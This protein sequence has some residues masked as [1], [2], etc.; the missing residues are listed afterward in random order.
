MK[1]EYCVKHYLDKLEF[2]QCWRCNVEKK[3]KELKS[4]NV[5]CILPGAR[6]RVTIIKKIYSKKANGS[7]MRSAISPNYVH[8]LD[9]ELLRSVALEMQKQ[10]IEN[11]DWI[12]DSFGCHPNHVSKMLRIT[13][14]AFLS[15]VNN[16]PLQR[17]DDQLRGQITPT[18]S[19]LKALKLVMVP[20]LQTIGINTEDFQPLI[21]SNWFF[22]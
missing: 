3:N 16:N 7:K 21:E 2:G 14:N 12:H 4:K 5:S 20:D 15:L 18:K 13:K 22:S 8:S 10:G 6:K 9:A 19:N 11:S 17:L 1:D